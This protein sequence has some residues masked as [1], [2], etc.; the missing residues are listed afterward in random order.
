M[1]FLIAIAMLGTMS[2]AFAGWTETYCD[3]AT[4]HKAKIHI[5]DVDN[6]RSYKKLEYYNE[7]R[8]KILTIK[9]VSSA[10]NTL[11][12]WENIQEKNYFAQV[13]VELWSEKTQAPARMTIPMVCLEQPRHP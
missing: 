13:E 1:K 8:G 11:E 3:S 10:K 4:G 6:S 9:K 12:I 5:D 2:S 7:E